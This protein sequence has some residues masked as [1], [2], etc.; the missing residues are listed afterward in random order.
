MPDAIFISYSRRDSE[1]VIKLASDLHHQVAG[2]WLDQSDLAVGQ[3]WRDQLLKG[4][5][6]CKVFL[7]VLSPDSAASAYVREEISEAVRLK[8]TVMPV[9][10][11]PVVLTGEL[12]EL[13][14]S[15]QFL[16]L[17]QGSYA[18]NFQKLVDGLVEAGI[19]RH[20]TPKPFLFQP[21]KTDWNA[22]IARVPGW[23]GAVL[24]AIS[25]LGMI[26]LGSLLFGV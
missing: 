13:V 19:I 5:R 18:D 3:K 25:S 10:Y 14:S 20:K 1:F 21:V 15:T 8:K 23:A 6:E 22:V 9:L 24:G 11:R 12:D 2:V 16:D 4:I 26:V 7:L 17:S